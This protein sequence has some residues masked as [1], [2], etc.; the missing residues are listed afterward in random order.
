MIDNIMRAR[1]LLMPKKPI[2]EGL[3]AFGYMLDELRQHKL[4]LR[5]ITKQMDKLIKKD[6]KK[7]DKMM[8]TLVKKDVPRD[9]KLEKCAKEEKA[10]KKGKK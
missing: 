1:Y 6:K 9:H 10:M 8:N 3:R 5:E 7:I 2:V 4:L